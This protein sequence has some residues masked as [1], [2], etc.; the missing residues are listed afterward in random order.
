[1]KYLKSNGVYHRKNVVREHIAFLIALFTRVDTLIHPDDQSEAVNTSSP[2]P[3][4][5]ICEYALGTYYFLHFF[6]PS[7]STTR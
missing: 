6:E 2:K 1:M 3:A 7:C 4:S 5:T